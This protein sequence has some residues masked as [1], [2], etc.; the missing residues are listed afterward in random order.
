MN[1]E[2]YPLDSKTFC[3]NTKY[4]TDT[5]SFL[6]FVGTVHRE[7]RRISNLL[8]SFNLIV[9]MRHEMRCSIKIKPFRWHLL[10]LSSRRLLRELV[11]YSNRVKTV[12]TCIPFNSPCGLPWV[13]D[14][15][16][17]R[18]SEHKLHFTARNDYLVAASW[19]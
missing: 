7:V 2:W 11:R 12:E 13:R 9:S 17:S 1:K 10:W 8:T 19:S 18:G 4:C 16:L 14:F 6:A 15:L 3:P 5:L